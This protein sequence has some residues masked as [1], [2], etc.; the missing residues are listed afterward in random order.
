MEAGEDGLGGVEEGLEVGDVGEF[1]G[2]G[3]PPGLE[4]GV[5]GQ[6]LDV[7]EEDEGG[8]V[9]VP[10]GFGFCGGYELFEFCD[11]VLAEGGQDVLDDDLVELGVD[12]GGDGGFA[13][14]W[15]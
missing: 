9:E 10:P 13:V 12:D 15:A 7:V 2:H 5:A 14:V 4:D 8:E 3:V 11:D 6:A 1:A